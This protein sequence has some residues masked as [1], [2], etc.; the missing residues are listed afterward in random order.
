M[1]RITAHFVDVATGAVRQTVKVDGRVGDIFALQ[2]KIVYELS[3]GLNL[4]LRGTEIAEI[5]RRE[6]RSVEAYESFAR[7]MMNLRLASRDSIERAIA[8]FEHATRQDPEYALRVGG[9]R[10]RLQPQ[11]LVPQPHRSDRKAPSRSSG[12]RSR[13]IRILP[14]RIPGSARRC[15]NLGRTDEAIASMREAIRLE[16]DNGQAHQALAR[17]FWVGKGD[18]AVGD[19][20]V[21]ARDRAESGRRL[22]VPAARACCWRGK[23]STSAPRKSASARSSSRISTSPATPACRWSVRTRGSATSI[24]CRADTTTRCGSTS[25]GL[26]FVGL[27]RPRAEGSHR[28]RAQRED[29]RG[30]SPPGSGR[31]SHAALRARAARCSTA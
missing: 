4:V 20:R 6:T 17:A 28:D 23:G 26:S 11:G 5:E 1:V 18:F 29:G 7:G 16:P 3:H 10:R 31:R 8:A 27:E 22:L 25:A 13:S 9:A 19:S 15:C 24:T 2:D 30:L 21:R 14:T 12:G